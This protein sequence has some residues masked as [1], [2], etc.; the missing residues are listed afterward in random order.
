[1]NESAI[2]PS[3]D[4]PLIPTTIDRAI[5]DCNELLFTNG[6]KKYMYV[7][8]CG[9]RMPTDHKLP[10]KHI[11]LRMRCIDC[12][13]D[14]KRAIAARRKRLKVAQNRGVDTA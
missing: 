7:L 10:P 6:H 3:T 5:V 14:Q 12:E 1:M 2:H 8:D 9:H 13:R 11:P 4:D